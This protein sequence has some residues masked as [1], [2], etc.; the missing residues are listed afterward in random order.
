M[1]KKVSTLLEESLFRR[2][3]MESVRQGKQ[4]SQIVGEALESYLSEKSPASSGTGV[5]AESW[6]TVKAKKTVIRRILEEEGG[7]F[8]TG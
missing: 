7:L 2:T 3:K 5:V 4:F 8:D 1:R 6:G